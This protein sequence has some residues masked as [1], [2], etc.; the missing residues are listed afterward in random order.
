M[1]FH[2]VSKGHFETVISR[3]S[4]LNGLSYKVS[5]SKHLFRKY[6]NE[7][8][9]TCKVQLQSVWLKTQN[10]HDRTILVRCTIDEPLASHNAL[11]V[12]A[13]LQL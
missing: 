1:L 6:E 4:K 9:L 11:L 2:M 3:V 13:V 12:E 7:M 5:C 8:E 10:S